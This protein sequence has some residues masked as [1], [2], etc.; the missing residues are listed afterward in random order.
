MAKN[1]IVVEFKRK[2]AYSPDLLKRRVYNPEIKI[3]ARN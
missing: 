1:K 2:T 3:C